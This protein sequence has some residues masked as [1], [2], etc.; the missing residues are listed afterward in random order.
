MDY[1]LQLQLEV[2]QSKLFEIKNQQPKQVDA[3]IL[4]LY[5][6]EQLKLTFLKFGQFQYTL[7]KNIPV[8]VALIVNGSKMYIFPGLNDIFY[9]II[10]EKQ[11]QVSDTFEHILSVNVR[12]VI[13]PQKQHQNVMSKSIYGGRNDMKQLNEQQKLT[14]Q[15]LMLRT[16]IMQVNLWEHVGQGEKPA[17]VSDY[18]KQGGNAIRQGLISVAGFIGEGI[19]KG[20][21]LISEKITDK[22][23]KEISEDTLNKVKLVNKGSKAIL[24]FTKA[25]V[26]ALINLGK[27]IADEAEKQ[28]EN[29]ETG[30]KM[31]EH[32]YYDDAKNVGGAA[33]VAVVSIYDGLTEALSVLLDCT[34]QATT[35]VIK[36]KYGDQASEL[37]KEGFQV[38]GNVLAFD[39]IYVQAAAKAVLEQ[40]QQQQQQQQ[41]Q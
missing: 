17:G 4:Q 36:N 24:Q 32:K 41:K 37:S 6:S 15:E 31:Q 27:L 26:D 8:M 20:G 30:K 7:Q 28:F 39:K 1:Q 14:Q 29:S 11:D 3:G 12:L 16:G 19:K 40:Q 2:P 9:G 10:V 35:E 22:E 13:S 5:Q 33:V 25:Q 21:E 34:G 18:I 38:A 23:Q